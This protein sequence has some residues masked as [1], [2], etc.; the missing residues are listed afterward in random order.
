MTMSYDLLSQTVHYT[1]RSTLIHSHQD[2]GAG[3]CTVCSVTAL[4]TSSREP[5]QA[6]QR[7]QTGL[8]LMSTVVME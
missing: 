5:T 4:P 7:V 1:L 6:E 2:P 8:Y 3:H